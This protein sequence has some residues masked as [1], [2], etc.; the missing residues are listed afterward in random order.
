MILITKITKRLSAKKAVIRRQIIMN[1]N[2]VQTVIQII[3]TIGLQK[4]V[5]ILP[6]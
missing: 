2:I 3:L 4:K 6:F 5:V 1:F